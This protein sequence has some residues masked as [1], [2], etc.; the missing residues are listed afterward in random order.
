MF[1]Y[2]QTLVS[3]EID[4]VEKFIQQ[5]KSLEGDTKDHMEPNDEEN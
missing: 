4:W 3:A 5:L 1:D 2:S